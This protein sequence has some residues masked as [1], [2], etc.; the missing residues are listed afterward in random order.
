MNPTLSV[1]SNP[2]APLGM[3][4]RGSAALRAF[5]SGF[6]DRKKVM[7]ALDEAQRVAFLRGAAWVAKVAQRSMRYRKKASAPGSPPSARSGTDGSLLRKMLYFAWD[8]T[9]REAI[10]GPVKLGSRSDTPK[11]HERGG[12]KAVRPPRPLKAGDV[13]PIRIVL[14]GAKRRGGRSTKSVPGD[15]AGRSVV[16]APLRTTKQAE[17][18]TVIQ[19]NVYSAKELRYPPRPYMGPALANSRD[20]IAEFWSGALGSGSKKP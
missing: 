4:S 1:S 14:G 17:L 3:S 19:R 20:K 12:T 16:Y 9:A 7:D 8:E 18:A 6:F 15:K 13:G 10:A 5:K 2:R 11:L